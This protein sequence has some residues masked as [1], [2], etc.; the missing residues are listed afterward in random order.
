MKDFAADLFRVLALLTG[1][2]LVGL[3]IISATGCADP[4]AGEASWSLQ[5]IYSQLDCS[6]QPGA[7][8]WYVTALGDDG[9]YH[10]FFMGCR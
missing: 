5:G 2:F 9:R 8:P 1:G 6:T 4:H 3:W 7:R 10:D